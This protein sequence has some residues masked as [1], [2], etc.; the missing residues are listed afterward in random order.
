MVANA[1]Q[2]R[3]VKTAIMMIGPIVMIVAETQ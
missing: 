1:S 2:R 3:K